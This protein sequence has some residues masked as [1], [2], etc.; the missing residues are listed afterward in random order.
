MAH[1]LFS[2]TMRMMTFHM[3]LR[4]IG[5]IPVLGSSRNTIC[6]GQKPSGEQRANHINSRNNNSNNRINAITTR[7]RDSKGSK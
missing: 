4:A 5:S 2:V 1:S 3:N 7:C 6:L